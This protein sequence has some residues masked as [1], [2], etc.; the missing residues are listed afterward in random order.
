LEGLLD[1]VYAS[2]IAE[3]L[4]F[5]RWGYASV[6][7]AH[8]LGLSLLVGAIVPLDLRLLGAWRSVPL[9]SLIAVL[10][11]VAASGLAL[12]M[13]TGA[14]LFAT[15]AN[16]YATVLLFLVKM[17]LVAVGTIHA[18]SAHRGKGLEAL[19]ISARHRVALTSML[20]WLCVLVAGRMLAF[21]AD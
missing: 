9:A 7:A 5:S 11:P 12:A 4:R 3:W 20:V 16:E 6:N 2:A 21:V 10:T 15:R 17:G 14:L 18:L 13:V 1:A 19:T 8:I